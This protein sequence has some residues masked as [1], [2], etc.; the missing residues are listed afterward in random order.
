MLEVVTFAFLYFKQVIQF[1]SN[2]ALST[3]ISAT[4]WS[5]GIFISGHCHLIESIKRF[6]IHKVA[7]CSH[8]QH[9][10]HEYRFSPLLINADCL[11]G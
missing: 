6:P 10:L 2:T 8:E 7:L 5:T 4:H 9:R 3:I 1:I 11:C